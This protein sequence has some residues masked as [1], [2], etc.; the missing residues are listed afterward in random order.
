MSAIPVVETEDDADTL[1]SSQHSA[2]LMYLIGFA[3]VIQAPV[4]IAVGSS[5]WSLQ[6]R[7]STVLAILGGLAVLILSLM[8]LWAR[9]GYRIKAAACIFLWI[10]AILA[11]LAWIA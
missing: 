9:K 1:W 8:I 7:F 11:F 4:C 6:A 10:G 5:G 3:I 2:I